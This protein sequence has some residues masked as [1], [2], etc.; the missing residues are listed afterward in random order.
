MGE[1]RRKAWQSFNRQSLMVQDEGLG[2]R[3]LG[4]W[5]KKIVPVAGS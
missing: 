1:N 5:R 2:I 4:Q 3:P